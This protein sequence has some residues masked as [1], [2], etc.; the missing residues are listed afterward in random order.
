MSPAYP[1][2][3]T[4]AACASAMLKL[5]PGGE[6]D[7]ARWVMLAASSI[8]ELVLSSVPSA[9]LVVGVSVWHVD[10]GVSAQPPASGWIALHT[11]TNGYASAR[12][13]S[14]IGEDL[15][16]GGPSD[17]LPRGSGPR[18]GPPTG[19][20]RLIADVMSPLE[21]SLTRYAAFRRELGLGAFCRL[22]VPE[23]SERAGRWLIVQVDL[24]E[25]APEGQGLTHQGEAEYG[26]GLA[27]VSASSTGIATS[28]QRPAVP[29]M[30]SVRTLL[31]AIGPS[32]ARAYAL[33][34]GATAARRAAMLARTSVSQRRIF[35]LMIE[36]MTE[37]QIGQMVH[38]SVHTVH[39]HVK[40]IYAA[41]GVGSRFELL[42][43]WHGVLPRE[44]PARMLPEEL[45]P[46]M[47]I[48]AWVMAGQ[49]DAGTRAGSQ[50]T[51]MA[52]AS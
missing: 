40:S 18:G 46:E 47:K 5:V 7:A 13:A 20:A 8:R 2:G 1:D 6:L 19:G 52:P 9:G 24:P 42:Q 37:R 50:A 27:D 14:A 28:E 16:R 44:H 32:I 31:E 30:V 49:T 21:F 38:R 43:L 34:V 35:E 17:D 48:H 33:Q 23:S 10:A 41:M 39:D 12:V 29:A 15:A 11:A 4:I 26:P 22:C 45:N 36:G 25:S 51:A 3:A